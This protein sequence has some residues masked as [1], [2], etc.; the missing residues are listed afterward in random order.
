MSY[1]KH[2]IFYFFR[3]PGL[4]RTT[5]EDYLQ[6]Q[7]ENNITK[8]HINTLEHSQKELVADFLRWVGV[9]RTDNGTP[10]RYALNQ[11]D[12]GHY[13]RQT[14]GQHVVLL[15][16]HSKKKLKLPA[17]AKK[18]HRPDGWIWGRDFVVLLEAK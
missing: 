15:L 16:L 11:K 5:S 1:Q 8:A 6:E 17:E 14:A 7:L 3:G 2:N 9:E 18:E 10:V 4:R 13:F 12:I